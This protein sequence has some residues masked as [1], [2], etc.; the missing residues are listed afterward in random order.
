M[1]VQDILERRQ[2]EEVLHF[3]THLG[4]VGILDARVVK[5][6]KR[7]REDQRLE[8]ILKLNTPFVKDPAWVD[9]VNLSLT[10]INSTL[11]NISADAWHPEVWWCILSF[12]PIILTHE[13]VYF[14][15]T[16]NVYPSAIRSQGSE[17]LG[18]LFAPIVHGRYSKEMRRSPDMAASLP[19]D[20][21]AEALYPGELRTDHLRCIYVAKE[22]HQDEVHGQLLA[23]DHPQVNVNINRNIFAGRK[24]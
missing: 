20:E 4:L 5:S 19:T 14:V 13:G 3:T 16:N 18:A 15:T 8:F 22:E 21:Q 6:R 10:R 24:D 7:L 11:F 12:D 23:L 17:G 1:T 9:Y 2:I